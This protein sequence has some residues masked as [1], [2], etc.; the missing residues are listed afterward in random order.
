MSDQKPTH[1]QI[2]PGF[3]PL[4]CLSFVLAKL[5]G[6]I[7][8]SWWLVLSPVLFRVAFGFVAAVLVTMAGV[9]RR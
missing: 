1:V 9:S 7:D 4:L 3:L 2:G 6:H 8:W 5:T